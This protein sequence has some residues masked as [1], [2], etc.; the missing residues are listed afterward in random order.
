LHVS[1]DVVGADEA[2]TRSRVISMALC[3][4][5]EL[6]MGGLLAVGAGSSEP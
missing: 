3:L 2:L 6:G 1:P 5:R 4:T